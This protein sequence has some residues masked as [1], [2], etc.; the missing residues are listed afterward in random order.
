MTY[1]QYITQFSRKK[2]MY[3]NYTATISINYTTTEGKTLTEGAS[4]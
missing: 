2:T 4:E 3:T 1:I